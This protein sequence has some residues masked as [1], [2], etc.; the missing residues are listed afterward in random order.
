MVLNELLPHSP[1]WL[2]IAHPS[3]KVCPAYRPAPITR[4]ATV[5]CI[6][7]Y[8]CMCAIY[9]RCIDNEPHGVSSW[10]YRYSVIKKNDPLLSFEIDHSQDTIPRASSSTLKLSSCNLLYLCEWLTTYSYWFNGYS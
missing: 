10:S 7:E 8:I 2:L 6:A 1:T 5:L 9:L 3:G 4:Y